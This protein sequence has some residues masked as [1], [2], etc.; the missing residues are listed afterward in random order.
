[1]T[2]FPTITLPGVEQD[3]R[4]AV[5]MMTALTRSQ[6][7]HTRTQQRRMAEAMVALGKPIFRGVAKAAKRP[8]VNERY[9][10]KMR[11]RSATVRG[12]L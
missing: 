1:M 12:A 9:A 4:E 8:T 2:P 11:A 10:A 6:E 3:A 5:T 7:S